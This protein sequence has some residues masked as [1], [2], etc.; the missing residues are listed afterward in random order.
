MR[1]AHLNYQMTINTSQ[2][3]RFI[4]P[5][6]IRPPIENCPDCAVAKVKRT[7]FG[8]STSVR[9]SRIRQIIFSNFWFPAQVKSTGGAVYC[10]TLRHDYSHAT[11]YLKTKA[12]VAESVKDFIR[13]VHTKTRQIVAFITTDSGAKYESDD[14]W[15]RKKGIRHE[16]TVPYFPQQNGPA[17]RDKR[18]LFGGNRN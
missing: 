17:E 4:L 2:S 7:P 3:R 5:A 8:N 1:L 10:C 6:N 18:T 11:Y 14:W 13:L 15:L 16:T 9:S 12:Q